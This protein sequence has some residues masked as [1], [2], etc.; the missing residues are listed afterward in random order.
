MVRSLHKTKTLF[1]MVLSTSGLIFALPSAHAENPQ[2]F[3]FKVNVAET[4]TISVTDPTTWA[5]G[6]LETYNPTTTRYESGL[7][8]NKVN[9]SATTNSPI[10]VTVSMYTDNTELRNLT[11]YNVSNDTTYIQTLGS[12]T[13]A[14]SFPV[15]NWGYSVN[16]TAAGDSSANYYALR[17]RTN[18]IELFSTI[19]T[20]TV[21]S[22]S[23]DVYFGARADSSK[24]SGTYA[25]TV[26][27]AAV[28][29]TIDTDNPQVPVNPSGPNPVDEIATYTPSTGNTTYTTR[30]TSGTGTDSVT[31]STD[32]TT[33]T[34]TAG[35]VTDSYAPPAGVTTT[36]AGNTAVVAALAIGA[37]VSAASGIAFFIAA[38][39]KD[40]DEKEG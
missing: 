33:T 15:N 22:G 37:A 3:D 25:Q 13:T 9:V 19:D 35:D 29:G 2:N 27:F 39:R 34:V 36:G 16:D 24:Q 38:R 14:A 28:T 31:G 18:P 7:L 32:T 5:I 10:G 26:Y 21:G 1:A 20:A 12:A 23:Q 4:L 6:D 17:T 40:E 11:S 8:R 30:T